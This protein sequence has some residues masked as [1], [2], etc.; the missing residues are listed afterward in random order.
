LID[1]KHTEERIA[2]GIVV[3]AAYIIA[4]VVAIGICLWRL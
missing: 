4:H 2:A 1:H 3:L